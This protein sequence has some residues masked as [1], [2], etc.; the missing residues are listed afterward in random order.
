MSYPYVY[1]HVP[2]EMWVTTMQGPLRIKVFE[3]DFLPRRMSD[4]TYSAR[5]L[6]KAKIQ[7]DGRLD[8]PDWSRA[9]VEKQFVFPWKKSAA[10]PSSHSMR[11]S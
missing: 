4:K 3:D 7:L 5:Y 1:E 2:G 11:L 6:P 8:E 9:A 10:P